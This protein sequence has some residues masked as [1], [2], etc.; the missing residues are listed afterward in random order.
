MI[1]KKTQ[2]VWCPS[3]EAFRL[4]KNEE[5]MEKATSHTQLVD[6]GCD[7]T[8]YGWIKVGVANVTYNFAPPKDGVKQA[9]EACDVAIDKLRKECE[10]KISAIQML[11]QDFLAL[12]APKEFQDD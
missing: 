6:E 3:P 12:P 4:F 2:V 5:N 8:P 11:K 10:E 9:V 7:M 1:V